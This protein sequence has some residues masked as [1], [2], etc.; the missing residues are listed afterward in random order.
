M[1]RVHGALSLA[2]LSVVLA[3]VLPGPG[4]AQERAQ[5]SAQDDDAGD[6]A[7]L[8]AE[9][10]QLKRMLPSQSHTMADVEYH[11]TNLWFAGMDQDWPLATFYFNETRS[12]L[13]WT[14]RLHPVRR[15]STGEVD[16]RPILD[17]VEK[18]GLANLAKAIGAQD[19]KAFEQAYRGMLNECY[20][21]HQASEKPYLRPE[22]PLVPASPLMIHGGQ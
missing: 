14:V 2:A 1:N 5:E 20:A 11:F 10:E 16:L 4:R 18:S 15:T 22:V 3:S 7:A 13:N 21:C 9:I 6:V 17:G 12:H 8:R 19:T